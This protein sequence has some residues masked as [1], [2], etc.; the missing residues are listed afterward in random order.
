MMGDKKMIYPLRK[1]SKG[2][3]LIELMIALVII[4]IIAAIAIPAYT[5][6]ITRTRRTDGKIGL[7]N[8]SANM[9]RFFSENNTYVGATIANLGILATSPEG[10]Y[11]LS[12]TAQTATTFGISAAPDAGG[13]QAGDTTCGTL[14]LTSTGI[15]GPTPDVCWR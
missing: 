7:L 13:P 10:Y 2:F 11:N 14:T 8:M 4:S 3:T 6:Q 9:E 1:H 15:Q 5:E 12:I